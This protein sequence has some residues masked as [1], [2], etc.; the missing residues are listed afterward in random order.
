MQK[1]EHSLMQE[2]GGGREEWARREKGAMRKGER[3]KRKHE[4]DEKNR[5]RRRKVGRI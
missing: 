3:G 1:W 4:R 2:E 5:R